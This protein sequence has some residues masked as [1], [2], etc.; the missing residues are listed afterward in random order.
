MFDG[1]RESPTGEVDG[2][3][4]A[5]NEPDKLFVLVARSRVNLESGDVDS[6][7]SGLCQRGIVFS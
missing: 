7:V 2:V 5:V 1:A 6:G 3:I 4:V